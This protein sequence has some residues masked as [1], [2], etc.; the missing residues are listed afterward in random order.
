MENALFDLVCLVAAGDRGLTDMIL[1]TKTG[2][3]KRG[4]YG[5]ASTSARQN[6]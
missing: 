6:M 1:W 3:R 4:R 5:K 2:N